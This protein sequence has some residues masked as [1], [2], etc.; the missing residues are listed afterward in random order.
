MGRIGGNVEDIHGAA[1]VMTEAGTAA[2]SSASEA[3]SFSVG[4][5]PLAREL[6]RRQAGAGAVGLELGQLRLTRL[7]PARRRNER[8]SLRGS[9][10]DGS[11]SPQKSPP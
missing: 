11:T 7:D 4:E 5:V 6:H 8:W 3:A 2:T 10:T 9:S 1:G